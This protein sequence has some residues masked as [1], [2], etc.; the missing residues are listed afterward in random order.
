MMMIMVENT[1][2]RF[3]QTATRS[4]ARLDVHAE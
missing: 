1:R 3:A 2:L 4:D